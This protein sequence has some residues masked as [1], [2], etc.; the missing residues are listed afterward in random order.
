MRS[1]TP[2]GEISSELQETPNQK[3]RNRMFSEDT[4]SNFLGQLNHQTLDDTVHFQY[5]EHLR[6]NDM[7]AM[8]PGMPN[9][10]TD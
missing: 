4:V 9:I 8:T 5:E 2:G 1:V 6:P 3:A 10:T 7:L